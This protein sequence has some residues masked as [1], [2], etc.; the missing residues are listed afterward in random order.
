M[1]LYSYFLSESR[2]VMPTLQQ[3]LTSEEQAAINHA[4]QQAEMATEAEI[5]P[6]IATISGRYDRGE[7]LFGLVVGTMAL[8]VAWILVPRPEPVAGS[9]EA[10]APWWEL[11]ALVAALFVGFVGGASLASRYPVIGQLFT[12]RGEKAAEVAAAARRVFQEVEVHHTQSRAGVLLYVSLT[13]R[14][15]AV[16]ADRAALTALGE[17]AVNELCQ[18][19]TTRLHSQPLAK[20]L[21]ETIQLTGGRL[22]T[23]L[24]ATS[25]PQGELPDAVRVV[26]LF[27]KA[28]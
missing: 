10:G 8:I 18:A 15:A 16:I 6:V 22:A 26:D 2:L 5:V 28:S 23:H 25:T 4:V 27:G 24:P 9:W 11:V 20:A 14:M 17:T 7:D 19:F 1:N 3:L 21:V 12:S 13:E